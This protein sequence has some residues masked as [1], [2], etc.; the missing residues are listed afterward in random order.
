MNSSPQQLLHNLLYFF[1]LPSE[2]QKV[3]ISEYLIAAGKTGKIPPHVQ[4]PTIDLAEGLLSLASACREQTLLSHASS[5]HVER[6]RDILSN[7]FEKPITDFALENG[8]KDCPEWDEIRRSSSIAIGGV[9]F[10]KLSVF[11][12][13]CFVAD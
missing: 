13:L 3:I 10:E 6:V 4:W 5:Y 7:L 1:S 8:L 9:Q 11:E 2:E 12:L